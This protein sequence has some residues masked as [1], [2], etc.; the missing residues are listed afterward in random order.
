MFRCRTCTMATRTTKA[1][2]ARSAKA[3]RAAQDE[4]P[5][6]RAVLTL[7]DDF[8]EERFEP[9]AGK[10]AYLGAVLL[11]FGGLA[12]GAGTYALAVLGSGK[13]HD[14]ATAML[15]AGALMEAGFFALGGKSSGPLVVGELGVGIEADGKLQRVAWWEVKR[16]AIKDGHLELSTAGSP[17]S[18]P[19]DAYV[20]AAGRIVAEARKRIPKRIAVGNDLDAGEAVAGKPVT[21]EAPQVAGAVCRATGE[22]LTFEKDVRMCGR[23]GA[24]YHRSGVPKRCAECD[25]KLK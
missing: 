6:A 8:V 15:L 9:A 18:F 17:L 23:C 3:D 1:R 13:W 16:I 12:L 2:S 4:A 25:H 7:E 21:A 20:G 11:S 24:L 14:N 19:L 22:A 10:A 5:T